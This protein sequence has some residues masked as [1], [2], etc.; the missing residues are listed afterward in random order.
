MEP[1]KI[2]SLFKTPDSKHFSFKPRYYNERQEIRDNLNNT[3]KSSL[4]FKHKKRN[5]SLQKGRRFKIILLIIILSLLSYIL[6]IN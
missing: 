2:P 1:P 5:N 6:L 3:V 4:I